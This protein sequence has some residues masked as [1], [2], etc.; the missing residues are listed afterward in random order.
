MSIM[1]TSRGEFSPVIRF[2]FRRLADPICSDRYTEELAGQ[3]FRTLRD[4]YL[5]CRTT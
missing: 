5:K 2:L 3:Q 1:R 4:F